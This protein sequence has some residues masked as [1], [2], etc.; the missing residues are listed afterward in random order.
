MLLL[1]SSVVGTVFGAPKKLI[2]WP[3]PLFRPKTDHACPQKPNP[4]S[5]T[6]PLTLG[7]VPALQASIAHIS[8]GT[9]ISCFSR[10]LK[11]KFF[12]VLRIR[13]V[14]PGSR[15]R[16]FSMPDPTCLHPGSRILIKEFQYFNPK[17]MVSKLLKIWSGLFIQ[18]P[19]S[20]CWLSIHPGSQIQGSKRHPIPDLGSRIQIRSTSFFVV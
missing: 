15:I 19:G 8:Y 16:L 20:G 10:S 5:E 1:H 12:S 14:Y 11:T 18:D 4:S 3:R 6:V 13:D 7:A 17:K 2:I 9:G